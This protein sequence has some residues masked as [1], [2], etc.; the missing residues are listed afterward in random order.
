[1]CTSGTFIRVKNAYAHNIVYQKCTNRLLQVTY[2]C[3]FLC[4]R[5]CTCY[6]ER[7]VLYSLSILLDILDVTK[8]GIEP[9][10]LTSKIRAHVLLVP[11]V[12]TE[13]DLS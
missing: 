8:I 3:M 5:R 2:L 13:P 10:I 7:A 12:G 4:T 6:C 1:M 9:L 11:A